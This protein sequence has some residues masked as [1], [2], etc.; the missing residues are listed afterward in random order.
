MLD[1][2]KHEEHIQFARAR[3]IQSA[4][5]N[6]HHASKMMKE[7]TVM[8]FE[9]NKLYETTCSTYGYWFERFILGCHKRMGD[10]VLSDYALSKELYLELMNHLEEDWEDAYTD[11]DAEK[12]KIALFANLLN[13]G[14]LCGH[15][16]EEIMKT[17]VAGFL[18]YLDVGA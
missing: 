9:I 4:Y 15:R 5:L 11:T 1:P 12:D 7:V 2:G 13:F 17:D 8:A 16:G 10:V 6:V 14:Y 3:K 18:K